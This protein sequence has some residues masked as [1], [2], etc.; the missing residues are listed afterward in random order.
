MDG[1]TALDFARSRHGGMGEGNDFARSRRQ[2]KILAA[3]KDKVFSFS[4]FLNP[5]RL[6]NIFGD[7]TSH[8]Q[9]DLELW[10]INRFYKLAKKLDYENMISRVLEAGE[11][12][13]L[14]ES[15]FGGASVL[16]PRNDNY[17][18]I[19]RL[20]SNLFG[21]TVAM[22]KFLAKIPPPPGQPKIQIQNGTWTL[23]LAAQIKADLEARGVAIES[24]E[25]A[26]SRPYEKTIIYNFSQNKFLESLNKLKTLLNA[27]VATSTPPN[28]AETPLPDLLIIVGNDKIS[29]SSL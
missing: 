3:L 15:Q 16:L 4:T 26:K 19:Q 11:N 27:E 28:L 10:E 2:Q 21:S 24:V 17:D 7:L 25:N 6:Q 18:E 1:Q 22:E 14:V 9:T 29:S 13:P 12:G 5:G 20:A 23:G 8:L